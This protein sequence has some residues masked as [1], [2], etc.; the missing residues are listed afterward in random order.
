MAIVDLCAV[1]IVAISLF[2]V[3]ASVKLLPACRD[4]SLSRDIRHSTIQLVCLALVGCGAGCI[5]S[6]LKL[7]ATFQMFLSV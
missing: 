7:V 6:V 1:G 4:R 3:Y 5:I 2:G